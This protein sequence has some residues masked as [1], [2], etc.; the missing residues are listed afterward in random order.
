MEVH[1]GTNSAKTRLDT[2][3]IVHAAFSVAFGI[4]T[5][6]VPHFVEFFFISHEGEAFALVDN[7]G[8]EQKITH[9][10]LR[11]YGIYYLLLPARI[12]VR[13]QP[14]EHVVLTFVP[15][16]IHLFTPYVT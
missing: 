16:I 10:I 3:F 1:T 12:L 5:I 13:N 2:L 14:L 9:L 11:L 7:S 6:L 8:D 15:F 4:L